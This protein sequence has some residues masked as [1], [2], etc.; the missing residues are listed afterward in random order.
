MNLGKIFLITAICLF[1]AAAAFGQFSAD[2]N[3][4]MYGDL[5]IWEGKGLINHLPV[6]R[7]YPPQ[8]VLELLE[9]VAQR[10]GPADSARA[11]EYLAEVRKPFK[12]HVEAGGTL[13][14]AGDQE[15]ADVYGGIEA[16]GWLTDSIHIEGRAKGLVMDNTDGFVLPRGQR[17]EVDIF[18]TW[19]DVTV[20]GRD[21]NLRQS[22]NVNFAAGNSNIYFQ[23]GI[24]R[25][26]F[27]PFWGD[28]V[29]LSADAPHAGHYSFIWRNDW[30]SYSTLLLDLAATSYLWSDIRNK[31]PDKHLVVQSFNFYPT[32]WLEIGYFESIVWGG[33]MDLTYLLPVKELFYAQ[34]M[35]GFEDN[36]FVGLMANVR[37]A[38][39][40]KIPFVMYLDDANLN[41]MLKFDFATK[42][43]V[44]VQAGVQWTPDD[45]GMLKRVQADYVMV[46]P[47]MYTHRAGLERGTDLSLL[48]AAE[49]LDLLTR[50]NYNNYTHMGTNLGVGM[51]PNSDRVSLQ[52]RLEPAR[53]L[54]VT[55]LGR[56]MRHGNASEGM[57]NPDLRNDGTILD[58]GYDEQT[59]PTFHYETRFLQQDV[60]EKTF[61]ASL[62]VSYSFPFWFGSMIVEGGYM[63]EDV[64]NFDYIPG[65]DAV[66]RGDG[67][68]HYFNLGA[69]FRY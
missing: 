52:V 13:R 56:Y 35:A 1:A 8:V 42:F 5:E 69:G 55:L 64:K 49:R 54:K 12:W 39:N 41:D 17:T 34:S 28:G 7:P 26:S 50:P 67:V 16:G 57:A 31:S 63:F 11:K 21:L 2:P 61:Q 51:E 47:Y 59:E 10:G 3:D 43:K 38:K 37:A 22:Q 15:Y 30:F 58:D 9:R 66:D 53:N 25:N 40:I 27:G 68:L 62:Q 29:V 46:T 45:L 14:V 20:K 60:I 23:A 36:S 33:R 44:A 32:E 24:M 18:D 19:A 65:R 48:L 6:M 4:P